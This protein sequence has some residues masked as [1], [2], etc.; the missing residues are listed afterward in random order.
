MIEST[1]NKGA[2]AV[3]AKTKTL[4]KFSKIKNQSLDYY[5]FKQAREKTRYDR[6]VPHF[7]T[8]FFI[9]N[10]MELQK[11]TKSIKSS[12]KIF[13]SYENDEFVPYSKQ[14]NYK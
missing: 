1:L 14:N 13:Q 9:N 10:S 2:Q 12:K 4:D 7:K 5:H 11:S 8:E 6:D 3:L